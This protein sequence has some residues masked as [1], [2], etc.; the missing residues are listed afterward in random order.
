MSRRCPSGVPL[1]V[2]VCGAPMPGLGQ[3]TGRPGRQTAA[4]GWVVAAARVVALSLLT[5][6]A[7]WT[8]QSRGLRT[9]D[10]PW[11]SVL[12][13]A[14]TMGRGP[15]SNRWRGC[16]WLARLGLAARRGGR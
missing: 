7:T 8:R 9:R 1:T 13:P 16:H 5:A 10:L 12:R 14:K 15:W 6:V 11:L 3:R 2:T 4:A